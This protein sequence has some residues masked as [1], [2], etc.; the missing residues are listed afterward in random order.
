MNRLRHEWPLYPDHVVFLGAEPSILEPNFRLFD[1]DEIASG[2]P[3][4]IFACGEG[5]YEKLHVTSAQKSQLRCYYDVISRQGAYS[6]L[7]IL[8]DSQVYE[9]LNWDAEKFRQN[10]TDNKLGTA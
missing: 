4:F 9:L 5:V 10:T 8:S 2:K 1:L 6:K 3:P 7:S